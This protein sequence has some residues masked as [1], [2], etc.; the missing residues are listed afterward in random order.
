M[1]LTNLQCF[2]LLHLF[3]FEYLGAADMDVFSHNERRQYVDILLSAY[4]ALLAKI[5]HDLTHNLVF[6]EAQLFLAMGHFTLPEHAHCAIPQPIEYFGLCVSG[7][8][9]LLKVIAWRS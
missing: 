3:I 7:L 1:L 9:T 8:I 2:P 4:V 5:R 6:R